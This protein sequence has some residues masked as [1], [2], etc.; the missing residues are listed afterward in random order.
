M[1]LPARRRAATR[2]GTQLTE[3]SLGH[4]ARRDPRGDSPG[5]ATATAPTGRGHRSWGCGST[6]E[7]LLLDPYARAVSGELV[8][9]PAIFG[10]DVSSPRPAAAASTP[11]RTS[12]RGWSST[13]RASTGATTTGPYTRWRDT[14]IYELHVKG[15]TALHDRVPEHLRGTYAGL[16]TPAVTDYLRDLGVTAVELLPVQQ[17]ASEPRVM[18]RG[19]ANYWGYN[20]IGFF[21]PHHDYS[22]SGDRGGQVREFKEMVKAFHAA[23]LEVDPRRRLQPHRRGLTRRSDRCRSAGSTT[24][25]S[26]T[27][28]DHAPRGDAFDDTYWDVTGCGNTVDAS[29]PLRAAA[30][31]RL[32]ALLD[33]RRC[34]STASA[35]T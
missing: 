14:V 26:T 19:M 25:P 27:A 20:T 22:S 8:D 7:K 11:R 6:R 13:T 9:D 28:V 15:M 17:F 10:Y 34:T 23:G 24:A 2:D 32:A 35:S 29:E 1:G 12:R 4:L 31:P 33:V 18:R 16:A 30:D 21:A 5:R 3:V